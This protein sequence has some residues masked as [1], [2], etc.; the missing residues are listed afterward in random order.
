MQSPVASPVAGVK[1][2]GETV[3]GFAPTKIEA[4]KIEEAS[5]ELFQGAKSV[6]PL[7]PKPVPEQVHMTVMSSQVGDSAEARPGPAA[8][9][10][11]D[12]P[13]TSQEGANATPEELSEQP[14]LGLMNA[15]DGKQ[16]KKCELPCEPSNYG[17]CFEHRK[18]RDKQAGIASHVSGGHGKNKEGAWGRSMLNATGDSFA[19]N[20]P[21]AGGRSAPAIS[22]EEKASFHF[23][24]SSRAGPASP[25]DAGVCANSS[26]GIFSGATV[27][28]AHGAQSSI[29]TRM[30]NQTSAE[31][32]QR[33]GQGSNMLPT[34][35]PGT[36][37]TEPF[38]QHPPNH[39]LEGQVDLHAQAQH[40]PSHS[41]EGQVVHQQDQQALLK[42]HAQA[43][44]V[45]PHFLMMQ[46]SVLLGGHTQQLGVQPQTF[47]SQEQQAAMVVT[48]TPPA[49]GGPTAV[50]V[51]PLH[52]FKQSSIGHSAALAGVVAGR[53]EQGNDE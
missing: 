41:L 17:F 13:K 25:S 8:N 10:A 12:F 52:F 46:R 29:L 27:S 45:D 14:P 51:E 28:N 40:P 3:F 30:Q 22:A 31:A 53:P 5:S 2:E 35:V 49:V 37:S 7:D 24:P 44:G 9:V 6:P 18:P 42:L 34:A 50:A 38:S 33:R 4:P 16:C 39:S 26:P 48:T 47:V 20:W 23:A 32:R 43:H 19:R 11:N 36:S 1:S 15:H 21:P